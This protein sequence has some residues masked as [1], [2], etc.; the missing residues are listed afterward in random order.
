VRRGGEGAGGLV[1]A[2][3]PTSHEPTTTTTTTADFYDDEI[4]F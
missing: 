1:L 4:P 3:A 2:P